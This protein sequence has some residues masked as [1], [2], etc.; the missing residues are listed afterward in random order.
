MRK[1]A[2]A[3]AAAMGTVTIQET[4]MFL[5]I[6]TSKARMPPATPIPVLGKDS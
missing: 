1:K 3:R 6:L 4:M 2:A 5:I